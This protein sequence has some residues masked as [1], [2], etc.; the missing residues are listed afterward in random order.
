MKEFVD[1]NATIQSFFDVAIAWLEKRPIRLRDG[2]NK[3]KITCDY[4]RMLKSNPYEYTRNN[5]VFANI[6][7][8]DGFVEQKINKKGNL[9]VN[10]DVYLAVIKVFD[11]IVSFFV[12]NYKLSQVNLLNAIKQFYIAINRDN[13]FKSALYKMKPLDY[14]AQKKR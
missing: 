7:K 2:E 8:L 4:L 11:T 10:N 3:E 6:D 13:L 12:H 14:F 1:Y 5:A 9:V